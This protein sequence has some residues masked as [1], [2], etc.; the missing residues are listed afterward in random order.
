[1]LQNWTTAA[2]GVRLRLEPSGCATTGEP[3]QTRPKILGVSRSAGCF[4]R[5]LV[6]DYL[7]VGILVETKDTGTPITTETGKETEAATGQGTA[8]TSETGSL[9]KASRHSAA[10]VTRSDTR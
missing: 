3:L 4:Q 5:Q 7:A 2:R 10:R 1:M 9:R 8:I 6:A